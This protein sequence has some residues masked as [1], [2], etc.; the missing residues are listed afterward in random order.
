MMVREMQRLCEIC[1]MDH[2]SELQVAPLLCAC[3]NF[4]PEIHSQG[5]RLFFDNESGISPL[6]GAVCELLHV[7]L[8]LQKD[9][10]FYSG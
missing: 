7:D 2:T 1:S 8:T 3:G 6:V 10:S 9:A 5:R 4:S